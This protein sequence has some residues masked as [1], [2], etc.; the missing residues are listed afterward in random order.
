MR[1]YVKRGTLRH[2]SFLWDHRL[3]SP[4]PGITALR[5][6]RSMRLVTLYGFLHGT[7]DHGV[8]GGD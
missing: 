7:E 8:I 2:D 1:P 6:R 3:S 5:P 4:M